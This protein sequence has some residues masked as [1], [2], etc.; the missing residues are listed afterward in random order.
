VS[1]APPP[2]VAWPLERPLAQAVQDAVDVAVPAGYAAMPPGCG[3]QSHPGPAAEFTAYAVVWPGS[4]TPDGGTAAAPDAD[5]D[6]VV[7][8][9]YVGRVAEQA[10]EMRDRGRG[11]LL[12]TTL[13]VTGRHCWPVR[14]ADSQAVQRDDDTTPPVWYAAD[15]YLIHTVPA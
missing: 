14:L 5:A 10:D 11:A 12:G 15:R 3:W 7:Q 13:T 4:T 6:Q 9:T 8:V 2:P 1:P